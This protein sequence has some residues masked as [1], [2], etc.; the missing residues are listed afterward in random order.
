MATV[1]RTAQAEEDIIDIWFYIA[2]ENQSRL[3]ADR[4]LQKMEK[5]FQK[6]AQTP[7][8]GTTKNEYG[9]GLY[10]FPFGKYLIF[11]YLLDDG[12][13][14]VRVLHGARNLSDLI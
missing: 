4:F 1:H 7:L 8:M 14:I 10:Q 12:I 6:L 9:K 11:Y 13:E 3:N 2:V 5:A